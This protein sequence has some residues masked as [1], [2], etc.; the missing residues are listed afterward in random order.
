MY[1]VVEDNRRSDADG[2]EFKARL[3]QDAPLADHGERVRYGLELLSD[4][5]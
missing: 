1:V 2:G 4:V 3:P 5:R